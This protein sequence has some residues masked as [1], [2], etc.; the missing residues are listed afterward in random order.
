MQSGSFTYR[1][2]IYTFG[3]AGASLFIAGTLF[4]RHQ[5]YRSSKV[6]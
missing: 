4:I 3:G 5:P 1:Y 2:A 6:T